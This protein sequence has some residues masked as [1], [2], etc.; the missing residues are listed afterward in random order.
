MFYKHAAPLGLWVGQVREYPSEP[1]P[2]MTADAQPIGYRNRSYS[3]TY[4]E[5]LGLFY[6]GNLKRLNAL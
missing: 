2:S 5:Q 3:A 4:N 6:I 1:K